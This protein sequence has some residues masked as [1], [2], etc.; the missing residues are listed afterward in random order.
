M[1][2]REEQSMGQRGPEPS[3][4]PHLAGATAELLL[5]WPVC[6]CHSCAAW[7]KVS[8][9]EGD[10]QE[11]TVGPRPHS[12]PSHPQGLTGGKEVETSLSHS[13]FMQLLSLKK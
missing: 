1:G 7:Q 12:P 9:T 4:G 2:P 13:P 6:S 11:L 5:R 10:F 3:G 8:G